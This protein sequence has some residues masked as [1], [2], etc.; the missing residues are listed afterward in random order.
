MEA[1]IE[2]PAQG[3]E[4]GRS[5]G[6]GAQK[7]SSDQMTDRLSTAASQLR[8]TVVHINIFVFITKSGR[9]KDQTTDRQSAYNEAT[10]N[11]EN[12]SP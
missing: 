6:I 5:A 12:K 3:N 10:D 4:N 2:K 1:K 8:H 9:N 7:P 11:A